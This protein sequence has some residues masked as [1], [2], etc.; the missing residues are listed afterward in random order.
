MTNNLI[1]E[2]IKTEEKYIDTTDLFIKG[3]AYWTI[4]STL[5]VFSDNIEAPDG[6]R[7]PNIFLVLTSPPA[8]RRS[9]IM[10][11]SKDIH[12]EAWTNLM[13]DDGLRDDEIPEIIRSKYF[14]D[15]SIEGI[16][17]GINET[18]PKNIYADYNLAVGEF[19]AYIS[20]T[21]QTKHLM[22]SISFLSDLYYGED[23]IQSFSLKGK[24]GGRYLA[25]GVYFT[26]FGGTQKMSEYFDVRHIRQGFMRRLIIVP[27]DNSD[28]NRY[29]PYLSIKRLGKKD[30]FSKLSEKIS[31]RMIELRNGSGTNKT[32][33]RF[34]LKVQNEINK[35]DE[36]MQKYARKKEENA[37]FISS[38]EILTKL[39][40]LTALANLDNDLEGSGDKHIFIKHEHL[41]YVLPF[42]EDIMRRTK[43]I[44][45]EIILPSE[46]EK[47]TSYDK[48]KARI[49]K[50]IGDAENWV[51]NIT[52]ATG[53]TKD[54]LKDILNTLVD[55]REVFAVFIRRSKSKKKGETRIFYTCDNVLAIEKTKEAEKKGLTA[56]VID[57][58]DFLSL[59]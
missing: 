37:Y 19:G 41:E 3:S 49:I 46:K 24:I 2:F 43:K 51:S 25:K 23:Y 56:F 59:Y 30:D 39:C 4:S 48:R 38:G 44:M 27:A 1:D 9:T 17:D 16:V 22:P 10:S 8:G 15:F 5:G 35:I 57:P 52:N 40:S 50:N 14:R 26:I 58:K 12:K 45:E 28:F 31:E 7:R 11:H 18:R 47:L 21:Q 53:K 32:L 36:R 34:D 54:T 42:F 55:E 33:M 20:R 13:K 6:A 29:L